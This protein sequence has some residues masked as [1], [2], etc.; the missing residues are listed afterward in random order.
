VKHY[1]TI[2]AITLRS[3][4]S[5]KTAKKKQLLETKPTRIYSEFSN[6]V[7]TISEIII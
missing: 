5:R 6:K 7:V 1:T 3:T 4:K 2:V